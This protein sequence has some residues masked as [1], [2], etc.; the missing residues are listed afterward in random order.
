MTSDYI[1]EELKIMEEISEKGKAAISAAIDIE[2]PIK[3]LDLD[4]I[5]LLNENNTIHDAVKFMQEKNIGCILLVDEKNVPSGIFTER[6]LLRKV[7]GFDLDIK[8][9]KIKE[10]MTPNPQMLDEND[11]IAF[12]LN[13]MSDGS[14]RHIPITSN[15]NVKYM[16]SVRDIVDQ[17]SQTFRQQVMNLPPDL[18][19]QTTQYGG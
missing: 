5:L 14:F 12:A 1:E 17:I 16:L 8:T 18:K 2:D 11:P 19:Q 4:I 3:I 6:D 7:I 10:Y 15:G 13:K 9:T